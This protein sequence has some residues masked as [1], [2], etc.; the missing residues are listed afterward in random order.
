MLPKKALYPKAACILIHIC[1]NGCCCFQRF[2][3]AFRKACN[4]QVLPGIALLFQLPC[5]NNFQQAGTVPA[6]YNKIQIAQKRPVADF[7]F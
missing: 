2:L 1:H 6:Q 3:I 7:P 5:R 4:I